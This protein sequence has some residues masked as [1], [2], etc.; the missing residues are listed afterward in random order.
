MRAS[1]TAEQQLLYLRRNPICEGRGDVRR[2]AL[3]W[4][5]TAQPTPASRT[6]A[7]RIDLDRDKALKVVV[8]SPD[9]PALAQG[10]DLPHV[11]REE[12]IE[13]CLYHPRHGE[14]QPWMRLDQTIVPWT[15]L[16]LF[17]FEDWLASGEWRGGGE[18]P[19][20]DA[21]EETTRWLRRATAR[22]RRQAF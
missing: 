19:E 10:R 20:P 15:F 2:G 1:L 21:Q 9:L 5:F 3:V 11:Y 16:W 13:L 7:I 17:Y 4:Q 18:H 8:E 14:W 22:P 6:Y 12:P